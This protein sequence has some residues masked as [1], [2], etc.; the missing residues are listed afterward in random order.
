MKS[1]ATC[2]VHAEAVFRVEGLDCRDEVVVL[3]RRLRPLAGIEDLTPDL[4]GQKLR[5]EEH[6]SELQSH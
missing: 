4:I 2:E 6:T 3:E 1:C 5:S